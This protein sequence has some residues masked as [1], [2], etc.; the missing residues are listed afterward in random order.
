MRKISDKLEWLQQ[1]VETHQL[2]PS[3]TS[4]AVILANSLNLKT[5]QCNPS[6]TTIAKLSSASRRTV[7]NALDALEEKGLIHRF[8]TAGT[9]NSFE[10]VSDRINTD[11]TSA[12]TDTS[13]KICTSAKNDTQLVQKTTYLEDSLLIDETVNRNVRACARETPPKNGTKKNGANSRNGIKFDTLPSGISIDAAQ[14]F[15]DHRKLLKAP[16]TQRAFDQ[17]MATA[18][19][20]SEIGMTPDEA[21]DETVAAGWR[22]I[23]LEWLENRKAK[24]GGQEPRGRSGDNRP[25]HAS[26]KIVRFDNRGRIK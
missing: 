24:T 20:A 14:G 13:S 10:L 25:L 16:L 5:G 22:G 15:V 3:A 11:R 21:I 23:K 17:A 7:H 12:K 8:S 6:I 1:V 19:R 4:I 26:H 18:A 9:K 2:P